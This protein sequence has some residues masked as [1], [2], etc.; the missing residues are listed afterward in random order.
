MKD[1]LRLFLPHPATVTLAEKLRA[2]LAGGIAILWLGL[3]IDFLPPGHFPLFIVASMGA[4]TLLLFAA[5]H[6]PMAQPWNLV[7]GH[8]VSALAGWFIS[9]LIKDAVISA[10]ISVGLAILFMH[11][12][13]A[14]HPPGAATALGIVLGSAQFHAMGGTWVVFILIINVGAILVLALIINNLLPGRRYPAPHPHGSRPVQPPPPPVEILATDIQQ[15]LNDM[16]SVIDVS[17][18]DLLEIYERAE[19]HAQER[20]ALK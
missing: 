13:D 8:L 5:P 10:A 11:L 1:F 19:R 2:G 3:L 7:I 12:L 20:V 18:D 15:A 14:L 17:E 4:S 6:S 16:D 9:Y